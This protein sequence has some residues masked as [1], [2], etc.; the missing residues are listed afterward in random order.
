MA[1]GEPIH[2]FQAL[3]K[4]LGTLPCNTV[5]PNLAGENTFDML[6]HE[7]PIQLKIFQLL[8]VRLKCTQ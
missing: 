6:T 7:T 5:S 8:K 3:L 1:D 2:N 4:D